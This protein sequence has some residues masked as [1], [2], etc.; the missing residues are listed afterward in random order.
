MH[1]SILS[2]PN[3]VPCIA[4]SYNGIKARGTFSHWG[5]ENLVLEPNNIHNLQNMVTDIEE[6]YSLYTK[7]INDN[8]KSVEILAY[9]QVIEILN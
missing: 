4:I 6:N 8:K 7:R 1:L 9:K 3:G 5:V 2:I